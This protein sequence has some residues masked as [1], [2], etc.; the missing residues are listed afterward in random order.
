MTYIALDNI[1]ALLCPL[2]QIWRT[3]CLGAGGDQEESD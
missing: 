3:S 2:Q 1:V